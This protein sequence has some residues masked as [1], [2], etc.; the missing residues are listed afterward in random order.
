VRGRP[1]AVK[2]GRAQELLGK[3]DRLTPERLR[4]FRAVELLEGIDTPAARR[5]L[6]R[7]AEGE[8]L[9]RLTKEAKATLE[10]LGC[11]KGS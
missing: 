10:R 4:Q 1:P 7:L 8:P 9:T 2:W 3:L 5:L 11:A 6:E